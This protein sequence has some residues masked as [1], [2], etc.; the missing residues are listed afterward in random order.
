MLNLTCKSADRRAMEEARRRWDAVAKPLHALGLLEDAIVNIAGVQG[1]ADVSLAPRCA[2]I[3]CADHGV[4]AQGVSQSGQEVTSLVA[5]SIAEGTANVNLMAGV[6]HAEVY[7]V[8][9]GMATPVDHPGMIA[10]SQGRGTADFSQ[11]PA[12]T[13]AQAKA[14]VQAGVDMAAKMRRDGYRLMA[15]GEMGIGNTTAATACLCALTGRNPGEL[16]GRGAGLSDA[17]LARKTAVI[18]QALAVNRPDAADPLDVL[19]KVGGFDIAGMTGACLGGMAC[20]LPV[21]LDGLISGVA[22]LLACRLCPQ[23]RDALLASHQ[24]REPAARLVLEE[25]GL[26]AILH[27]N[28][29]LGEGTGAVALMPVLDMALAV[30]GG[31]HTFEQLGM[32]AYTPQ[33]GT[34]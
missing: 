26:E 25:L 19:A 11:G 7:A 28:M 31:V 16:T 6:A 17:G 29:A 33:G 14:A 18:R 2:V 34:R 4:V 30:Y 5:R 10:R 12:M 27:G 20:G 32:A 24:S 9:M 22:A 1:T 13:R 23:A 15:V 3:F 8:D 21:I